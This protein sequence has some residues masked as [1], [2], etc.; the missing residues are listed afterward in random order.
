MNLEERLQG[1]HARLGATRLRVTLLDGSVFE[2]TYTEY[3]DA[4]DNVEGVASVN[5]EVE[6][7][8]PEYCLMEDEIKEISII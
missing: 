6:P 8:N 5:I 1:L 2:G 7:D 4:E 3:T